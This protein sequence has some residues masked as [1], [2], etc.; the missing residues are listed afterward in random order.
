[1]ATNQGPQTNPSGI[2]TLQASATAEPDPIFDVW[3]LNGLIFDAV[4]RWQHDLSSTVTMHPVQ[5]GATISD[6]VFNNQNRIVLEGV[7]TNTRGNNPDSNIPLP[8]RFSRNIGAFVVLKRMKEARQ[9]NYLVSKY[10][11]WDNIVIE[12]ISVSDDYLTQDTFKA[13]ISLIQV[14]ITSVRV[15]TVSGLPQTTDLT[16]RGQTSGTPPDDSN[17]R[18]AAKRAPGL[19]QNDPRFV[20]R[21]IT[22]F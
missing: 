1:M 5:T 17:W 7:F 9:L 19:A 14:F 2:V 13:S 15:I 22:P 4:M 11:F 21:V 12:S 18:Q 6:H 3:N 8:A 10:G 16:T 20:P